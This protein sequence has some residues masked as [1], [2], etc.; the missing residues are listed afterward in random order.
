MNVEALDASEIKQYK[1]LF[2]QFNV[3]D[4]AYLL[5]LLLGIQRERDVEAKMLLLGYTGLKK[6]KNHYNPDTPQSVM[7]DEVMHKASSEKREGDKNYLESVTMTEEETGS[8]VEKHNEEVSA[9]YL[10]E[11]FSGTKVIP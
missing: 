8:F 6:P 10:A 9:D 2:A 4:V 1:K 7:I 5:N 11:F 3:G